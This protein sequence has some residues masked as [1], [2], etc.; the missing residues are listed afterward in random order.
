MKAQFTKIFFGILAII[1][2]LLNSNLIFAQAQWLSSNNFIALDGTYNETLK[3]TST[4]GSV[5]GGNVLRGDA[6]NSTGDILDPAGYGGISNAFNIVPAAQLFKATAGKPFTITLEFNI[7]NNVYGQTESS[8]I[9]MLQ[10]GL[11]KN[12]QNYSYDQYI[13]IAQTSDVIDAPNNRRKYTFTGTYTFPVGRTQAWLVFGFNRTYGSGFNA[14][15]IIVLPFVVEGAYNDISAANPV[16]IKGYTRE[17]AIPYMVLHNP[18]GDNST[19]T[20]ATNQEACRTF[21]ETASDDISNSGFLDITLGIAGS[22]GLFVTTNF[23]FSVTASASAGGGSASIKTKGK[24]NCVSSLSSISTAPN[25]GGANNGSIFLG[26]STDLVYGFFPI[27]KIIPGSSPIVKRDTS[28]IFAPISSTPFYWTKQQIIDDIGVK[29]AIVNNTTNSLELRNN[30]LNQIKVWRQVLDKDSINVNNPNN[31][32]LTPTFDLAGRVEINESKTV[33]TS[34]TNSYDVTHYIEASAGVS[35]VINV[36]GSGVEGGYEFKT[37]KSFGEN[38]ANSNN[39]STTVAYRLFDDDLGDIFKV[40]IVRDP[41][42]GTPIFL[43]SLGTKSSW[44]YE[45]GYQRDQPE[46]RFTAAPTNRNYTVPNVA[47][48]QPSIFG[49]NLCN[50]SNETRSYNMRFD[51]LSNGNGANI[52]ISG[53]SGNTEFGSFSIGANSCFPSTFFATVTQGNPAALSAQ[54]LNLQLYSFND[55]AIA[56]DIYATCNWGNYTLPTGI[57]TSQINI[58]QGTSTNVSLTANCPPNIVTTWYNS[59][60]DITPIGTGSPFVQS[61]TVNSNYFVS[62]NNG[63]YNYTRF[64][65]N[66]VKVNPIPSSPIISASGP[67]AFCQPGSVTLNSF[68]ANNNA[69][70][71]VRASN[72]YVTVPHSSSINLGANF[73]MEAW[74]NYSGQNSTIIDKGNYDFLWQLNPNLNNSKMGF[75]TRGT[76]AWVY[77]TGTIPQNVWTHVAITLQA[78]TLTFYINGV[79]S[80][81]GAITFS[82]DTQP[83]NIGRQQPTACACNHFNGTMDELRLWNY[84]RTPSQILANMNSV[85]ANIYGLAAYYKFDETTGNTITDASGNNNTGT[86]VNSPTRQIPSTIPSNVANSLWTPVNT[87]APSITTSTF[88]T[89]TATVTNGFG[90]TNSAS[91]VTSSLSPMPTAQANAYISTGASITLTATGCSGGT[92]TYTLKW[93]KSS[94]N[95]LVTMPVSP[96]IT[97][98]YYAKCEQALNSVI[99]LSPASANVT[100]NVGNYINSIISGNWENTSTWA[101]SRVPLPTDNVIINNHTVT[102]TSN[103]A[104]A[105]TLEYKSGAT[106]RYLNNSAKLNVGL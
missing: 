90:C 96:A 15:N 10:S 84:A 7:G 23:E 43:T 56:S 104:N 88:G 28:L 13:T 46:L 39:S 75:Y 62:C 86:F 31:V 47:V 91:V 101:P 2:L 4:G 83:M 97:T 35:A 61:P 63:I 92:G 25:S 52:A 103:A 69:L 68:L 1:C 12:D 60:T 100:V 27:V 6:I 29:Q 65:A 105:K 17:P 78:G 59:P 32:V 72:Q 71:F 48:G 42:Y 44:P 20:F 77:S 70:S 94:D 80:G 98:N 11:G 89:Y 30:A 82:Q 41:D 14:S 9:T 53:T 106:L 21:T 50:N 16:Q 99:C 57:S 58:C 87:T 34:I 74:V 66:S 26:Y 22:A 67:L 55:Q 76:G 79:A 81:T 40:K 37:R 102:I 5:G 24:Q 85:P 19:I 93:Y 49:I 8:T 95:S 18:P 3:V 36:G 33:S 73:T 45:G 38:V 54:N 64:P 51:P